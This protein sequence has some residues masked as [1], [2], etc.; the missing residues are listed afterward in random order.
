MTIARGGKQPQRM[1]A[2]TRCGKPAG[3]GWTARCCMPPRPPHRC[4][5]SAGR[6]PTPTPRAVVRVGLLTRGFVLTFCVLTRSVGPWNREGSLTWPD[7]K[8]HPS[9]DLVPKPWG[10]GTGRQRYERV[11]SVLGPATIGRPPVCSSSAREASSTFYKQTDSERLRDMPKVTRPGGTGG[12][13]SRL[14]QASQ[15]HS[16]PLTSARAP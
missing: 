11:E 2:V 4:A 3:L 9:S 6:T 13:H 10:R 5:H 8:C 1:P 16:P 14:L 15:A 7:P 12:H